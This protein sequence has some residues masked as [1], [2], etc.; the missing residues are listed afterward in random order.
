MAIAKALAMRPL[1]GRCRLGLAELH[2]RRGE[3]A[4]AAAEA[5]RACAL[6]RRMGMQFWLDR[7]EA[8]VADNSSA[9]AFRARGRAP[10]R[11]I[12]RR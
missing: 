8:L 12:A 11:S 3:P 7:A 6:F 9:R 4:R 1:A 5:R 10:A 2:A